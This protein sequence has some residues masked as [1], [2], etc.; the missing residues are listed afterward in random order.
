MT[1]FVDPSVDR[2]QGRVRLQP[3]AVLSVLRGLVGAGTWASPASSWRTFGLGELHDDP[4]AELIGRLFGVRD[5]AL[6]QGARHREPAVRRAALRAGVL[7]DSVDVVATLI[8]LRRGAPKASGLLVGGGAALFAAL[9]AS[10]LAGE[11][12]GRVG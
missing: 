12:P 7:C 10:A 3:G 1:T 8:A 9:G 11:R 5:L 6:A 2:Q 4:A